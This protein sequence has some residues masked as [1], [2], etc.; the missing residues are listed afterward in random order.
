MFIL[1]H[2]GKLGGWADALDMEVRDFQQYRENLIEYK[3]REHDEMKKV[4]KK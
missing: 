3:K 2:Y 4:G 1:I